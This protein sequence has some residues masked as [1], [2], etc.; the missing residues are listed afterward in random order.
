[1][2]R[3]KRAWTY[4]AGSLILGAPLL[5]LVAIAIVALFAG[6]SPGEIASQLNEEAVRSAIGLSFKTTLVSLAAVVV[7]GS[8]IALAMHRAP[9]WLS[10]LL[11]VLVTLPAIMPPSV[12]GIALLMAFGRQ[13]LLGGTFE[14]L[15]LHIAFTPTAVVM[16]QAFVAMPF[17]VRALS[18]GL[19]A[20]DPS[21]IEAA[22][23]DG[24]EGRRLT[25]RVMLPI[26]LPFLLGGAALAW[27]RAVGEFGATILFAGNMPGVTQTMPLAIYLG[28][29]TDIGQAKALSVILMLAAVFVLVLSRLIFRRQMSFA[30]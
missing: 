28:F 29:E 26:A 19:T 11:E 7:F 5:L 30:H 14:S 1:M 4:T 20:I 27:A 16:A 23:L 9:G 17:F 25:T 15:G 8:G 22:R 18:N 21:M 2:T 13:G 12:A 3:D 6:T 10:G 24:A